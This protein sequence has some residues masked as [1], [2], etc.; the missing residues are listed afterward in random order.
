MI[1]GPAIS[2]LYHEFTDALTE[3][4]AENSYKDACN[5]DRRKNIG[6]WLDVHDLEQYKHNGTTKANASNTPNEESIADTP[7]ETLR[8][9]DPKYCSC[10]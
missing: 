1:S 9:S 4:L 8:N 5:N 2:A 3:V 10:Y 7:P 6:R